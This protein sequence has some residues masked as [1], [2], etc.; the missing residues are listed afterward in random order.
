M[1]SSNKNVLIRN[2]SEF[3]QTTLDELKLHFKEKTA[4]QTI[5]KLIRDYK[6]LLEKCE[7]VDK[8]NESLQADNNELR[9]KIDNLRNSLKD[10]QA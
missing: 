5:I 10:L 7:I 3:D 6:K 2:L 8:M 9:K 1:N 4:S